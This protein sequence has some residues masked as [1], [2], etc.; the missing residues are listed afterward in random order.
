MREL[1]PGCGMRMVMHAG[2]RTAE[3]IASLAEPVLD[4]VHVARQAVR[5][6]PTTYGG[7]DAVTLRV[8]RRRWHRRWRRRRARW[9]PVVGHAASPAGR[10]GRESAVARDGTSLGLR[11]GVR[12]LW[13]HV[14]VGVGT[15]AC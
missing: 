12:G 9:R 14:R 5:D 11:R 1:G 4:G 7:P 10:L 15:G 6:P 13:R 2:K 8:P 3:R